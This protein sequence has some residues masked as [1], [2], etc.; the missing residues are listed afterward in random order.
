M[1]PFFNEYTYTQVTVL[2]VVKRLFCSSIVVIFPVIFHCEDARLLHLRN[3]LPPAF[4]SSQN[5]ASVKIPLIQQQI[6]SF[7]PF[8]QHLCTRLKCLLSSRHNNKWWH[9]NGG[10]LR[11]Q[12]NG[13]RG[14]G[15]GAAL[16]GAP[17]ISSLFQPPLSNT[18]AARSA[19]LCL[20]WQCALFCMMFNAFSHTQ[21][22]LHGAY[23]ASDLVRVFSTC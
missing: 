16:L 22:C 4:T 11:T 2:D 8:Q 15:R 21:K 10:L 17:S 13:A 19:I 6:S 23:D 12:K 3:S 14:R 7:A 20:S 5:N 1:F 9:D 18:V